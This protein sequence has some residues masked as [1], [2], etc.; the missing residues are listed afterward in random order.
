MQEGKHGHMLDIFW[1][2]FKDVAMKLIWIVLILWWSTSLFAKT[3]VFSEAWKGIET[4]PM[5]ASVENESLSQF[6]NARQAGSWGDPQA[7]IQ[8][9]NFTLDK[10]RG[11][12]KMV[13]NMQGIDYTLGQNIPLT[14]KNSYKEY[15]GNSSG[16]S[17]KEKAKWQRDSLRREFWNS[18]IEEE[19]LKGKL[20][21][22]DESLR[23]IEQMKK[24]SHKLYVLG[25]AGQENIY[26]LS[27]RLSDL[28]SQQVR[29]R[30]EREQNNAKLQYIIGE[31]NDLDWKT[32][33]WKK[34][35]E[36]H[37]DSTNAFIE[38]AKYAVQSAQWETRAAS[39]A[40][41]P[42]LSVS[43][44]YT[45]RDSNDS[46][47]DFVGGMIGFTIPLSSDKYAK[48][49]SAEAKLLQKEVLYQESLLALKRQNDLL[50][51][52]GKG[53]R[54]QLQILENRTLRDSLNARNLL[55]RSYGNGRV[56]LFTLLRSE[57][58]LNDAKEKR[59]TLIKQL[60]NNSLN[61]LY[62]NGGL[63]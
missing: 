3:L 11:E 22:I 37:N 63:K 52:E 14:F 59:L 23:W 44:T 61:S 48:K 1:A 56:D 2:H 6:E 55:A 25:K 49:A 28:E 41:V 60:K 17:L 8:F 57:M 19:W 51:S 9:K 43:L 4:H 40:F 35:E 34:L 7:K 54:E 15:S 29:L 20:Q 10:I 33:P 32:I 13:N 21:I 16:L 18:L 31:G 36:K 12:E 39:L 58:T 50:K 27:I 24:V 47:G 53:L 5:V 45:K 46:M 26:E 30:V 38:S 62:F 42:D